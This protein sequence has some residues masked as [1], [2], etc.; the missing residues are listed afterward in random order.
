LADFFLAE[1]AALPRI[2][3]RDF[4][5]QE[6]MAKDSVLVLPRLEIWRQSRL[7]QEKADGVWWSAAQVRGCTV[8]KFG[9]HTVEGGRTFIGSMLKEEGSIA[10]HFGDDSTMCIR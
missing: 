10:N 8:V 5:S 1:F 4:R 9:A 7:G 3:A 2:G 6:R